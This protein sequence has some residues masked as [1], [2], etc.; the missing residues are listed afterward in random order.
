VLAKKRKALVLCGVGHLFHTEASR[1]TAVSAYE[2]SYPGRTF[3]ILSHDGFAAFIDLDRGHQLEARMQAWP[4]P[5]IAPI[6]GT[7]LADLDLP[8]FLWPFPRRMAG[9]AIAD[10]VDAYLYLGPG[11]ALVYEKTPAAILDDA[12]YMAELSRRFG[13]NAESLRRR[14]DVAS[15]F[16]AADRAEARRFAPGAELVGRY[17]SSTSTGGTAVLD[18]DFRGGLVS[19]KLPSATDW[20][21]L[22]QD[23]G[24]SRY[25]GDPPA[26]AVSLDFTIV[27][28]IATAVVVDA[29]PGR[30]RLTL[31]KVR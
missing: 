15:L 21:T 8:Y 19:A 10:K 27:D 23:A 22:T 25:R 30:P 14:N 1:A 18:V 5:S 9:E 2:R 26:Q 29:G 3:V 31:L 28:G 7:W 13:L 20:V 24:T 17:S 4:R 16:T 11:D 6:K 12:V